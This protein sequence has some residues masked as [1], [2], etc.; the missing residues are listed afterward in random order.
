VPIDTTVNG[1]PE[2]IRGAARW[3]TSSVQAQVR[4]VADD[5]TR[6]RAAAGAA[7]VGQAGAAFGRRM[8][9]GVPK[10]DG[11][12]DAAGRAACALTH[13]ADEL[14]RIQQFMAGVRA[15][16]A[17]AGLVVTGA[18]IQEPVRPP[19]VPPTVLRTPA[20]VA[21]YDQ[22][23]AAVREYDRLAAAYARAAQGHAQG[24]TAL[25]LWVD[26]L[27]NVW[28][29]LTSKWFFTVGDLAGGGGEALAAAHASVLGQESRRLAADGAKALERFRT[30]SRGTPARLM[31]A[32]W[33][34]AARLSS[35]SGE[36]A[37]SAGRVESTAGKVALRVGAGLAVAGVVYDIHNGKPVEQAV[38][39]GAAGFASSVA[40]GALIGS[41][42][43]VPVV[44]TVLGAA[45]GAVVGLFVSGAV[46]SMYQNG[47]FSV[48]QAFSGGQEALED[49]GHAIV[50][51]GED[52][53]DAIF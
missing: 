40:A 14:A 18:V 46:D 6:V 1:D 13:C 48:R 31:Y 22:A 34:S 9:A 53:W 44:G 36:L 8:A 24:V 15:E 38:V 29:D 11:L 23:V 43:P 12:A 33:D 47:V 28:G 39:S 5:L 17:A 50:G 30:A 42:I 3:L 52:V 37:E 51:L 27:K 2:S 45:G 10:A 26:T 35:R 7:W 19:D 32:D 16:A 20:E 4:A 41:L 21:A 49:T 25:K